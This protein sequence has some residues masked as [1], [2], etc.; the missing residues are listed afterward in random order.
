MRREGR[1]RCR[2]D[3]Q[4]PGEGGRPALLRP[5]RRQHPPRLGEDDE[6]VDQ[7]QRPPV[8]GPQDGEGI[9]CQVLPASP[10]CRRCRV[11]PGCGS[12]ET[13]GAGMGAAGARGGGRRERV[14][15]SLP[16]LRGNG[17]V[18]FEESK[19]TSKSTLRPDIR[20]VQSILTHFRE[21]LINIQ[22]QIPDTA[23]HWVSPRGGG[24]GR[25]GPPPGRGV[26]G[27]PQSHVGERILPVRRSFMGV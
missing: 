12:S 13:P 23:F 10:E 11:C 26:L 7:E 21:E 25:G 1:H 20:M 14:S 19:S 18:F 27:R 4:S 16:F 17:I 8:L 6:G 22:R 5:L 15:F 3:L 24:T 2:G 9:R